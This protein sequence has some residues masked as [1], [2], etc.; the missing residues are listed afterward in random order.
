MQGKSTINSIGRTLL[1]YGVWLIFCVSQ[2]FL[3]LALHGVIVAA[4]INFSTNAWAPR[5]VDVW[6]MVILGMIILGTIFLTETYL[7]KG[8]NLGKFWQRVGIVALIEGVIAL[9]I[10]GLGF[11]F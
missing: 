4:A 2:V 6:S 11:L 10:Y 5:A 7:S 3:A 1:I 8:M 9:I